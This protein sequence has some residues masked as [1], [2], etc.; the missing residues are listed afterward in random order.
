[1][2]PPAG[3]SIPSVL[4]ASFPFLSLPTVTVVSPQ[5]E[6]VP[7]AAAHVAR[8]MT[9]YHLYL[10]LP[11]PEGHMGLPPPLLPIPPALAPQPPLMY[12]WATF[13][14]RD[15]WLPQVSWCAVRKSFGSVMDTCFV[16][17][18]SCKLKGGEEKEWLIPPWCW[19]HLKEIILTWIF[20]QTLWKMF[21]DH[22]N[23]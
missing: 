16:D 22:G 10:L 19:C 7:P 2:G 21:E 20:S 18:I 8:Q 15:G 11:L 3:N 23:D 6:W 13:R 5:R 14:R 12:S 4:F 9:T 17:L 1:M